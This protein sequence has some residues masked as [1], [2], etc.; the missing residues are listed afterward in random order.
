MPF[1]KLFFFRYAKSF[2]IL[3]GVV[4]LLAI[5]AA[6]MIYSWYSY[7]DLPSENI[8]IDLPDNLSCDKYK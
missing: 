2:I 8:V 4:T 1:E 3:E 6:L 5:F 7:K